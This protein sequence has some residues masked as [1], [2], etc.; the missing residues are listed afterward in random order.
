MT[1]KHPYL[2]NLFRLIDTCAKFKNLNSYLDYIE[3]KKAFGQDTRI[4]EFFL[5]HNPPIGQNPFYGEDNL[6]HE[7]EFECL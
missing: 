4:N 7:K 2:Q 6:P 3:F 1:I 5:R